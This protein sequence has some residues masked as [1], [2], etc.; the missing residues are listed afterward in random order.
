MIDRSPGVD[1]VVVHVAMAPDTTRAVQPE[2]PAPVNATVPDMAVDP[3][4][5]GDVTTAV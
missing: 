1:H 5:A 4:A 3:V 2:S